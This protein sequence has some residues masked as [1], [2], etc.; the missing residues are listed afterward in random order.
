MD[1]TSTKVSEW[2]YL[3]LCAV[4]FMLLVSSWLT[5]YPAVGVHTHRSQG[6]MI[7]EENNGSIITTQSSV[8]SSSSLDYDAYLARWSSI[9]TSDSSGSR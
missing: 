8:C 3:F 7:M 4:L 1:D 2:D 5:H 9:G 6:I